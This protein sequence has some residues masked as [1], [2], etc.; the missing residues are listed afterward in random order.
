MAA[1]RAFWG[2]PEGADVLAAPGASSLIA[3][4]PA[5][6]AAGRVQIAGPTYNEHAAAF[7]QAGWE[8]AA[9]GPAAAQVV[10][11]P[12]N[13]DGRLWFSADLA[14]DLRVI[15]ESFCDTMPDMSLIRDAGRDDTLVLKSFGKFWGLG[16][17]RLGFVAGPARLV[18]P[19]RAML[20][21]WPVSGPALEIGTRAL[22]DRGWAEAHRMR[23]AQSADR[24]DQCILAKGAK[25]VGGTTLF[26]LYEVD[27]ATQWQARLARIQV[28]SRVFPYNPRWLRLGL[29][30]G[31]GWARLEADW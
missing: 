22:S 15:D 18:D 16:G 17:L 13:P 19:L 30:P 28:W 24:L 14:G 11:H 21:P 10:V 31:G 26:R 23:L 9:A 8:V 5:L 3:R 25:L 2:I 29:P 12:N 20:G 7:Q 27:R 1:A 6:A 4:I